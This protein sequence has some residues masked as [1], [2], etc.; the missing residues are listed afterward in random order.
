MM[1]KICIL[2]IFFLNLSLTFQQG[3]FTIEVG[4]LHAQMYGAEYACDDGNGGIIYSNFNCDATCVTA[5]NICRAT[6]P[7]N[8]SHT[9]QTGGTGGGNNTPGGSSGAGDTDPSPPEYEIGHGGGGSGGSSGGGS[10]G[11]GG[12][13]IIVNPKDQLLKNLVIKGKYYG[14]GN[15]VDCLENAKRTM[16]NYGQNDPGSSGNTMKLMDGNGTYYGKS[17]EVFNEIKR[18]LDAGK[19]LVGGIDHTEGNPRKNNDG[20]TDHFI[21]ISGYGYDGAKGSYYITYIET[22][23]SK[24]MEQQA[25]DTNINRLYY[26]QN[27]GFK[28]LNYKKNK[29]EL[30]HIRPNLK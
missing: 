10:G 17:L 2:V 23:R 13:T 9:C 26:D 16:A 18:H 12:G 19:M 15:G 24:A 7:C 29:Y 27:G 22:G 5:C 25:C 3:T 6:Y 20:V 11:G 21:I 8:E 4:Q 30:T 14:Y 28:G 1:K